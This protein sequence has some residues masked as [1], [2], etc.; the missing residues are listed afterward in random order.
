MKLL[1]ENAQLQH[2]NRLLQSRM[3]EGLSEERQ[4]LLHTELMVTEAK[5]K[6]LEAILNGQNVD[7]TLVE[8]KKQL[9]QLNLGLAERIAELQENESKILGKLQ[10]SKDQ[11]E[12]LE[13]RVLELE[14]DK[15]KSPSSSNNHD[16]MGHDDPQLGTLNDETDLDDSGCNSSAT[17]DEDILELY[18][19]FRGEKVADTKN[20]LQRLVSSLPKANDKSLLLQTVALF[21][22]LLSK[23]HDLQ[24]ENETLKTRVEFESENRSTTNDQ[25]ILE[26]ELSRKD[27]QIARQAV[28]ELTQERHILQRDL[29]ATKQDLER[30]ET[31]NAQIQDARNKL[32]VDLRNQIASLTS[33]LNTTMVGRESESQMYEQAIMKANHLE[34]TL[35][36]L[37]A[38]TKTLSTENAELK[39][40]LATVLEN[41]TSKSV[42][43]IGSEYSSSSH[44]KVPSVISDGG[45]DHPKTSNGTSS[46]VSSDLS[47]SDTD[48]HDEGHHHSRRKVSSSSSTRVMEESGI[49]DASTSTSPDLMGANFTETATQTMEK[50]LNPTTVKKSPLLLRHA[51][52]YESC[53]ELDDLREECRDLVT[54]KNSLEDEIESFKSEIKTLKSTMEDA[55]AGSDDKITRLEQVE[56]S[57]RNQLKEWEKKYRELHKQNQNLLE[58]KC[59]LEEAENDSRLNAQRWEHQYRLT[60]DRNEQLNQE[61]QMERNNVLMVRDDLSE[62]QSKELDV[63]NDVAYL[64]ALVQRYEQRIFDLEEVEVELR[65][66]LILLEK[67]C[68]VVAW[69]HSATKINKSPLPILME[70][71]DSETQTSLLENGPT[72]DP[73]MDELEAYIRNLERDKSRLEDSLMSMM[74]EKDSIARSLEGTH[75]D[76]IERI[77]QLEDRIN[78]LNQAA[79]EANE[80]HIQEI[81]HLKAQLQS[82]ETSSQETTLSQSVQKSEA[83]ETSHYSQDLAAVD[84]LQDE[85]SALKEKELAY[86]QT[87]QE[88]D[89]ILAKVQ[90]NYEKTIQAL[91][92]DKVSLLEK[93]RRMET[94]EQLHKKDLREI[95]QNHVGGS[96]TQKMA[97]LLE[98]LMDTERTV[99][100][101]KEVI[102]RLERSE[103]EISL[104]ILAEQKNN[105]TF[106]NELHDQEALVAKLYQIE[107]DNAE[108]NEEI[109]RLKEIE[110]RFQ[111]RQLSEGMLNCREQEL[112]ERESSLQTEIC[113][114]DRS[115]MERDKAWRDKVTSLSHELQLHKETSDQLKE[116]VEK[117]NVYR[118]QVEGLSH[119]VNDM[120]ETLA[121]QTQALE[122]NEATYRSELTKLRNQLS[123][124]T[125]QLRDLDAL[126]STLQDEIR[127]L[128]A[129]LSVRESEVRQLW[130]REERSLIDTNAKLRVKDEEIEN[131]RQELARWTTENQSQENELHHM[132]NYEGGLISIRRNLEFVVQ[133]IKSDPIDSVLVRLCDI[134]EQLQALSYVICSQPNH[135]DPTF[136][137]FR[138]ESEEAIQTQFM[139]SNGEP[140]LSK[141]Q[142]AF[143]NTGSD[144]S[145]KHGLDGPDFGLP[146]L[147]SNAS[148][149]TYHSSASTLVPTN[150]DEIQMRCIRLE[151]ELTLANQECSEMQNKL[152]DQEMLLDTK[153]KEIV[154]LTAVV[155]HLRQL[156]IRITEQHERHKVRFDSINSRMKETQSSYDQLDHKCANKDFLIRTLADLMKTA[157]DLRSTSIVR[158]LREATFKPSYV[159][160]LDFTM[161]SLCRF[162]ESGNVSKEQR[163]SEQLS[164]IAQE[165]K[166]SNSLDSTIAPWM[167]E[168]AKIKDNLNHSK[169]DKV[170]REEKKAQLNSNGPLTKPETVRVTRRVGADSLL[171]AWHPPK[172][173]RVLGYMIFVNSEARQKVR[174]AS[175]TKALLHGLSLESTFTI[176]IE[177]LGPGDSASQRIDIKFEPDLLKT[178]AKRKTPPPPPMKPH[179]ERL[180]PLPVAIKDV[181]Q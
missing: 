138:C 89:A 58:E 35:K 176:G 26:M 92:E 104:K 158:Y 131:L 87:I 141:E 114:L 171:L 139:P 6:D 172:D 161:E 47:D 134:S 99:I 73:R 31:K 82:S 174:S 50:S 27:L 79:R 19:D 75:E 62:S 84:L 13:F 111:D 83:M 164:H 49:F 56:Y 78:D 97:Q 18:Q 4:N 105:A 103:R 77:L 120:K 159:R 113:D 102:F 17:T 57:L 142:L 150:A 48:H 64:E 152:E 21:E 143:F 178:I 170:G 149:C 15:T 29:N 41:H 80:A 2:L 42:G 125:S 93:I 65:E 108:L 135:S 55:S 122:S 37:D 127:S 168:S 179:V 68:Y 136:D 151:E 116:E 163:K 107:K 34:N 14:E 101:L 67:A 165:Y 72:Q 5:I 22:T 94:N 24:A 96:E 166:E 177:S 106:K 119:Q 44:R 180:L 45:S 129:S 60:Y 123:F 86:C 130:Q 16:Q 91:E 90:N 7:L 118:V 59:E 10:D 40:N 69:F 76:R 51:S 28:D 88:A 85:L 70:I 146:S 121:S 53:E 109:L 38:K 137:L 61:L 100:E 25:M 30:K 133:N 20:Q 140:T 154:D 144:Y 11:S 126:N 145:L 63:R 23:I 46:G 115:A 167:I 66:K 153:N 43:S 98:R 71:H 33:K 12:L 155:E 160:G 74:A 162:I 148:S 169:S 8:E 32:E 9:Q 81:K 173:S 157:T 1:Q 117:Q 39:E 175:R 124:S 156:N 52:D 147:E 181:S 36:E 112:E 95:T 132:L 110:R 128:K 54:R 3:S